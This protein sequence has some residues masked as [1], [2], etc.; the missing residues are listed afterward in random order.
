MNVLML[1]PW[2]PTT[3]RPLAT[4]PNGMPGIGRTSTASPAAA[5]H[6]CAQYGLSVSS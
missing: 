3:G 5:P 6:T 1:G 2:L 4:A